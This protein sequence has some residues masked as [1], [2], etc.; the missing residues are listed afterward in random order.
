MYLKQWVLSAIIAVWTSCSPDSSIHDLKLSELI[1][2]NQVGYLPDQPK[3][4]IVLSEDAVDGFFVWDLDKKRV[5]WEGRAERIESKTLSEKTT[6]KLDF[7]AL[8]ESGNFE[9]GVRDL[10]KSYPFV[11]GGKAY[12]D[13]AAA[14]LKAFYYQRASVDLSEGFA[15]KWARLGGHP[16]TEVEIHPSAASLSRP[17]GT[18]ISSPKGW[19]DAGDYNKYIVN[20]G[21]TVGTLLSLYEAYPTFFAKQTLNIPESGDKLPDILS[22][23]LWNLKWMLSMQDPTDGGVYHKLTT[24]KFEG[25]TLEPTK[26][27]SRR[28]VM[29]KSTA[30][31]LDFAAVMAQASRVFK[32][33]SPEDAVVYQ[34][35]A[36]KA[37]HW[38]LQNPEVYYRQND[39]N[40]TYDPDITTGAYGDNDLRD[41]WVWAASELYITSHNLDYWEVLKSAELEFRLPSWSKVGWLGF[42][43][44]IRHSEQLPQIPADW[45]AML[46]INLVSAGKSYQVAGL[47]QAYL[48]PMGANPK[49]F[50]WGSNAVASNQGILF[51]EAFRLNGELSFLH[52]AMDNLDYLLGRNATG[53]CYV[54]GFGSRFPQHP[55]HRLATSRPELPPPP[56]FLVGGP[57]PSQP[58]GCEYPSKI[59][60]ESYTDQSCSY[61]S[62]EIAINWNA[63]FAYMV[64]AIQATEEGLD[65]R[66]L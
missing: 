31:A 48:S 5:A 22:E 40:E 64:N 38:A 26:A 42:Y 19:Y 9:L 33:F 23:I 37:W 3:V 65:K 16:D 30:A 18:T 61:A 10:G 51:I 11:I 39:L 6:W 44:L 14:S 29:S 35:A 36:E 28:Y 52:A 57:N 2:I 34:K 8:T 58:D 59:P 1:R 47:S 7:S 12:S 50:I 27:T 24:A 21:I 66:N 62:N 55:H 20:S 49:D 4:A 56:G 63:A 25:M 13:L 54:T 43:S 46:K 45:I 41:E 32:S 60:D 17:A 53:F 15:G